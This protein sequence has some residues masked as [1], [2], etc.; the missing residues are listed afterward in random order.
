[1]L[2]N[3]MLSC[4]EAEIVINNLPGIGDVKLHTGITVYTRFGP[5]E[6][7]RTYSATHTVTCLSSSYEL[8]FDWTNVLDRFYWV[9]NTSVVGGQCRFL[10][11][12]INNM[13]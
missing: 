6:W 7:I 2:Y 3:V 10:N 1:M 11:L 5:G 8:P 4:A 12:S 13:I 9:K